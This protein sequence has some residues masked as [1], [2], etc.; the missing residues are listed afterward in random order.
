MQPI[1]VMIMK[2]GSV[3]DIVKSKNSGKSRK[4]TKEVTKKYQTTDFENAVA[5]MI[6]NNYRPPKPNQ[7]QEMYNE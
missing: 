4:F 3:Q 1:P 6:Q 7:L 2:G 5:E